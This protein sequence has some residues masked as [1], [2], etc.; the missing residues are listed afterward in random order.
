MLDPRS[1]CQMLDATT[2]SPLATRDDMQELIELAHQHHFFS[3]IGPRCF[4]PML[5][6]GVKGTSTIAGSGCCGDDGC[7]PWYIKTFAAKDSIALGAQ[8]IDMV[9][10][11]HY[12]KSGMYKETVEDIRAVKEAIGDHRLKCIIESPILTDAEIAIATQLVIDGGADFVKTSIGG[13]HVTDLRQVE[14]ISSVNRGQIGIK[15]S[16]GI[17]DLETVKRMIDLGVTRFGI[18]LTSAFKIIEGM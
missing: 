9:M 2:I 3:V 14:I 15:A 6:E 11:L 4:V 10:N 7:E 8:E 13:G 5:V 17:R 18:G 1:F 16:G 12:F